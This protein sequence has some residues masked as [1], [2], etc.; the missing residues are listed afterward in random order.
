MLASYLQTKQFGKTEGQHYEI[1]EVLRDLTLSPQVNLDHQFTDHDIVNAIHR[2]KHRQS[3]KASGVPNEIWKVLLSHSAL[4]WAL[5][6]FFNKCFSHAQ[7]PENWSIGE[8]VEIFK[9]KDPRMPENYRP[10]TITPLLY[11][12]FAKLMYSRLSPMLDKHQSMD[13]AGFRPNYF[14]LHSGEGSRM[15]DIR[16][17]CSARL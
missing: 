7:L 13:Q 9:K 4:R 17:S 5:L 11:K 16:L 8:I 2:L 12:L 1:P 10:I 14:C 15:A 6:S 3:A